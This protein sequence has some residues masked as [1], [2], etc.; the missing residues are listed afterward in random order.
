MHT[1]MTA[2]LEKLPE[3]TGHVVKYTTVFTV[4]VH[5]LDSVN[6]DRHFMLAQPQ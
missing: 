3:S 6:L 2:H 4:T 1:H 5:E